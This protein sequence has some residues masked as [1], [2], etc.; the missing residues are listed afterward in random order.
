MYLLEI[1]VAQF[2][3]LY[4]LKTYKVVYILRIRELLAKEDTKERAA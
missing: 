2:F 4:I 3:I 1:I